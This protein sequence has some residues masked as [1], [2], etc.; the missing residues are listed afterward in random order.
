L[1]SHDR[2]TE[3]SEELGNPVM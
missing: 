2:E 3:N 1:F